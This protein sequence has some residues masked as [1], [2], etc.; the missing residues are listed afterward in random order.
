MLEP[1]RCRQC[2]CGTL[3]ISQL[4]LLVVWYSPYILCCLMALGCLQRESWVQR[5]L[6]TLLAASLFLQII[7]LC[8]AQKFQQELNTK[9]ILNT[10]S[11]RAH[12]LKGKILCNCMVD[13]LIGSSKLFWR[14][15]SILQVLSSWATA[16]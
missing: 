2:Y 1:C 4:I 7:I 6:Q 9:W 15:V 14:A 13:L 8:F 12:I 10:V 5:W 16:P 3:A 11:T